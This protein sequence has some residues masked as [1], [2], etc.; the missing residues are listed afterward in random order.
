[1]TPSLRIP[2]REAVAPLP[3]FGNQALYVSV[4]LLSKVPGKF[5]ADDWIVV[6]SDRTLIFID[7]QYVRPVGNAHDRETLQLAKEAWHHYSAA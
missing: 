5:W 3:G 2:A 7:G 6:R 4:R 1:V